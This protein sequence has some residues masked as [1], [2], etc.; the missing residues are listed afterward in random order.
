MLKKIT[1]TLIFIS[2]AFIAQANAQANAQAEISPEKKAAIK[3]L[4]GLMNEGN[5]LQQVI[6]L[7]TTQMDSI[8]E[9][10]V[11]AVLDEY[12]D[13][14]AAERKTVQDAL[15]SDKNADIKRFTEKL[16][17]KLNFNQAFVEI[18][19]IVYDKH[20][21][22]DEIKELIAFYKTPTGQKTLKS[23]TPIMVDMMGLMQ[24]RILSKLPDVLKEIQ[25]EEKL[26]VEKEVKAKRPR[27]KNGNNNK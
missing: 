3:E 26:D 25:D 7:L 14:T 24:D 23:V 16:M 18:T 19:S 9:K 22:L 2:A 6:D 21:T 12:P 17:Q 5:K 4:I 13:L 11:I 10:A 1:L 20:Y 15:L 27:P 8:R